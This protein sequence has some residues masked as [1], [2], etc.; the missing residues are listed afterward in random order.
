MHVQELSH[1]QTLLRNHNLGD[2]A[3][4]EI[5]LLKDYVRVA[6][7]TGLSGYLVVLD[8]AITADWYYYDVDKQR[9][10]LYEL[11]LSFQALKTALLVPISSAREACELLL[12]TLKRIIAENA[13]YAVNPNVRKLVTSS[14]SSI[15]PH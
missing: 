11:Q 2:A 6:R 10:I 9:R 7:F 5:E 12:L 14:S 13:H 1:R 8:T 3:T 4:A 15:L